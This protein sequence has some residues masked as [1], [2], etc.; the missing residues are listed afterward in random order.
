MTTFLK[1]NPLW[2]S[3]KNQCDKIHGDFFSN[4]NRDN[5]FVTTIIVIEC[6]SLVILL[7]GE[8]LG[9]QHWVF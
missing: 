4:L 6:E 7:L 3:Y 5:V 9:L 2:N 1:F 8:T